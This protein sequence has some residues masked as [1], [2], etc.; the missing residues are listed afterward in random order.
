MYNDAFAIHYKLPLEVDKCCALH[1]TL[2][3]A[4]ALQCT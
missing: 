3:H 4:F 1:Y 2:P